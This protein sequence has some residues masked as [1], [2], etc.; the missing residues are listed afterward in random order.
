MADVTLATLFPPAKPEPTQGLL[1][2]FTARYEAG[3][4][5]VDWADAVGVEITEDTVFYV[6]TL[7]DGN[8]YLSW[9]QL[10]CE[11]TTTTF[12]AAPG[13]EVGVWIGASQGETDEQFYPEQAGEM[14]QVTIPE[15]EPFTLNGLRNVRMGV[16]PGEPGMEGVATDFLPQE[17]LTREVL[18][19][20]SRPI[21]FMTEDTYTCTA[22]DDD[23]TLLVTLY[24]P[25]GH[26]FNYFSGYVFMP[27]YAGSDLWVSDISAI[28]EDYER[29]CEGTPW[30]AGEYTILYTIDGGEVAHLTFNL[31]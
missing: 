1:Q 22:E 7:V 12:P 17:P 29:F 26:T 15:A 16:T 27:E 9:D 24:T 6:Y 30:P 25:E 13:T 28:F 11:D 4:L 23:H 3:L 21:Y 8:L 10:T 31:E 18:A 5:I 14:L 20:R 19:D 2:E